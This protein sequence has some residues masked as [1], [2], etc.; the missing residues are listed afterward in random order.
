MGAFGIADETVQELTGK[1]QEQVIDHLYV[2]LEKC[3]DGD[4]NTVRTLLV[5]LF[6]ASLVGLSPIET[7]RQLQRVTGL[8]R[9]KEVLTLNE[10]KD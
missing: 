6:A 4:I 1:T 3:S 8:L 7:L 10:A 2:E 9:I 5:S